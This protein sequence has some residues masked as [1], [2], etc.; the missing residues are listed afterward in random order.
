MTDAHADTASVRPAVA[1]DAG[2]V[3][4]IYNHYVVH[5]TV[6]F[7]E[8]VVPAVEMAR[9]MAQVQAA[10]LPWLVA[11][12]AGA[13]VGYAYAGKWRDRRSYRFSTEVTVYLAPDQG[14]RGIGSALYLRLLALLRD[15]GLHAVVGVVALPNEASVRLHEKLGF[16]KVGHLAEVGYKLDRWIDVGYWQLVL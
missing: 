7:E 8:E 5:T 13:V 3:A 12:R 1:E 10:P 14:G 16:K 9:R 6:T 11:E 4:A 2:A 15:R